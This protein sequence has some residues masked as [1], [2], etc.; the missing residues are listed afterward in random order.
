[1]GKNLGSPIGMAAMLLITIG[2]VMAIVGIILLIVN[3]NHPKP[4]YIWFL[5]IT[6]AVLGIIGGII[7]AVWFSSYEDKKCDNQIMKC[8][9]YKIEPQIEQ[10]NLQTQHNIPVNVEKIRVA[11]VNAPSNNIVDVQTIGNNDNDIDL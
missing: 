11:K 1:M 10:V 9:E 2:V 3:Q 7:L 8:P 5:L 4:W 6:G